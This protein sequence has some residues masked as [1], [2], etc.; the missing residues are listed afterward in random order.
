MATSFR[1]RFTHALAKTLC[2][3]IA[4]L[5]DTSPNEDRFVK[6][7]EF[8]LESDLRPVDVRPVTVPAISDQGQPSYRENLATKLSKLGIPCCG[9]ISDRLPD[10]LAVVVKGSDQK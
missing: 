9:W 3:L 4:D 1:A 5:N 2:A 8:L 10:L 6:K 7:L